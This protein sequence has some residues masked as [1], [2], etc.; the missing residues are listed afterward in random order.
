[1]RG[2]LDRP[3]SPSELTE[4]L[5]IQKGLKL[6]ASVVPKATLKPIGILNVKLRAITKV[7]LTSTDVKAH[8]ARYQ[9]I[10]QT[11]P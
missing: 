11:L 7:K 1:M 9:L 8:L 5:V 6:V 3:L 4:R 2:A 10:K